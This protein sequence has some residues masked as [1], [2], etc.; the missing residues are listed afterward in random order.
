MP[1]IPAINPNF[2]AVGFS[3]TYF[4]NNLGSIILSI[5]GFLGLQGLSVI[6]RKFKKKSKYIKEK[7]HGI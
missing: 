5:I 7:W 2:S 4:I 6:C 3:D 1:T